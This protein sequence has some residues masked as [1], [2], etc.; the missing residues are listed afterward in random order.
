MFLLIYTVDDLAEMGGGTYFE[1]YKTVEEMD[2]DVDGL[3]EQHKEKFRVER[4]VLVTQA[5]DYIPANIVL[6]LKRLT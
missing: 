4:A 5:Y 2:K 6:K 1:E 3:L